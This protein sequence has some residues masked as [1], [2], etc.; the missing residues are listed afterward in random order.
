MRD[1]MY[2]ENGITEI[3]VG[4]EITDG[5][6]TATVASVTRQTGAWNYTEDDA[7]KSAG[8]LTLTGVTGTFTA[9]NR[10][11]NN[12]DS[13]NIV[14]NGSF[15]SDTV[16]NKG[17][18]WTISAGTANKAAGTAS[19]LDQNCSAESGETYILVY[20]VSGRTGGAV[21][22]KIGTVTGTSVNANGT[23]RDEI[24]GDGASLYFSADSSFDGS[25]DDV[26]LIKKDLVGYG[27]D[28]DTVTNG[29]FAADRAW[30]KGTGWTISGGTASHAS[31]SMGLL[32]HP[33]LLYRGRSIK[34]TFTVSGM[35]AGTLTPMLG[36]DE[37]TAIDANGTYTQYIS[38]TEDVTSVGFS[39]SSAFD[40]SIDD[41][42]V[43]DGGYADV[44]SAN[45]TYTLNPGGRYECKKHN[46]TNIADN[47]HMYGVS[48]VNEAFEFDGENYTPIYHPDTSGY[49]SHILIHQERLLLAFPGG[50]WPYSVAGQPRIFNAILG[51]GARSA[52]AD[53]IS[54]HTVNGNAAVAFCKDNYWMLTGDGVYD[55]DSA[56]RNWSF[57]KYDENIGA[58]EWSV[59]GEGDFFFLNHAEI[60]SLK[61]T[62]AYGGF[63]TKAI[64]E[65]IRPFLEERVGT[66][67]ATL[68]CKEKSQYR[69][70]YEDGKALYVTF[71]AG[72]VKGQTIV[73][74]PDIPVVT[75]ANYEEG[76]EYMYF[77]GSDGY[78]YRM[79][80]GDTCDDDYIEGSFRIPF[81]HYKTPRNLKDI[82]QLTIELVA[83]S[84]LTEDT[85]ISY[86]AN[87]SYGNTV[88]PRANPVD[89]TELD[90]VGGIYGNNAGY[91]AFRFSGAVVSEI[92][93]NPEGYGS[94]FSLLISFRTKYDTAFGFLAILADVITHGLER[95]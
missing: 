15:G 44:E 26:T 32:T 54:T 56:T 28:L 41:V 78:V 59:A 2:F 21:Q 92:V 76:V 75:W 16:W 93:I 39:A 87:W 89:V 4:D 7:D 74:F 83:P 67:V 17:T 19:D 60:R 95:R 18:G 48:G 61:T 22:P 58:D 62:E 49:P 11:T 20:T 8:Y 38:C 43:V 36:S 91:G 79:D 23:Y 52:G 72:K 88:Y 63:Y 30:D 13:N 64:A 47:D 69:L 29:N 24:T 40:G 80:S 81:H 31:G 50:E 37:G 84:M 12:A 66:V 82:D 51:A 90:T 71:F 86:I 94:N 9:G 1:V 68:Y 73:T 55:E 5:S 6:A 3:E 77:G 45:Q 53:I 27:G 42:T 46:F 65:E 70:F 34:I 85:E 33:Y 10:L 14:S 35:S 57:H 25:I